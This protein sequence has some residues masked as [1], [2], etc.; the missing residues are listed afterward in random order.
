MVERL[1]VWCYRFP[2]RSSRRGERFASTPLSTKASSREHSQHNWSL[3]DFTV[4]VKAKRAFT[5]ETLPGSMC[6]GAR[7]HL[8]F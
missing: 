4:K 7:V 6:K 5:Q 2:L 3:L 1:F 8:F